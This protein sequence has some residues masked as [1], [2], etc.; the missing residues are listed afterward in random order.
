MRKYRELH[1]S[2]ALLDKNQLERHLEKVAANHNIVAKSKKETYPVPQLLQNFEFITFFKKIW[3]LR[4]FC[5]R[6]KTF[7]KE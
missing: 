4:L 5:F 3:L 6:N 1:I 7:R 2:G